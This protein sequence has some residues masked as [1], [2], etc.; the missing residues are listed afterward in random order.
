M[1]LV[2]GMIEGTFTGKKLSEFIT[3]KKTDFVGARRV[4]NKQDRASDIANIAQKYID[5]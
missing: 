1:I 2:I 5:T 4:V 3:D